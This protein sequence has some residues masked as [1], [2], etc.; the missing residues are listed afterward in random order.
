MSSAQSCL[1]QTC[2]PASRQGRRNQR[3]KRYIPQILDRIELKPILPMAISSLTN[4]F[5]Y[6]HWSSWI[7]DSRGHLSLYFSMCCCFVP[8]NFCGFQKNYIIKAITS[9]PCP[10]MRRDAGVKCC[11]FTIK[12]TAFHSSVSLHF[13][14]KIGHYG[15]RRSECE[16]GAFLNTN[17]SNLTLIG[18]KVFASG[19]T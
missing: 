11:L 18:R 17:C 1:W 7:S 8:G 2:W 16:S 19:M 15:F 12:K 10:K 4:Q 6:I 9:V 3:D 14:A 13:W 5:P